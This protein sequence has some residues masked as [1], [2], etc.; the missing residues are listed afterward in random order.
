VQ[1]HGHIVHLDRVGD[2]ERTFS[3][4]RVKTWQMIA[5]NRMVDLEELVVPVLATLSAGGRTGHPCFNSFSRSSPELQAQTERRIQAENM[6]MG[7][8]PSAGEQ[9]EFRAPSLRTLSGS[10]AFVHHQV[11][12]MGF[13]SHGCRL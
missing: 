5:L 2:R 10:L 8:G 1:A 7:A 12:A 4:S 6:R 9:V 11:S 13:R 3:I